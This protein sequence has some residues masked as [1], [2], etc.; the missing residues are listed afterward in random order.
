[1][2]QSEYLPATWFHE[3]LELRPSRIHGKGLFA[4]AP[5]AA[6]ETVMVWRGDLYTEEEL[7]AG[8][9]L[10]SGEWSFSMIDE[11]LY[12]FAPQEGLDYYVNHSCD[13]TVW[14]A[15]EVT[16]V[17]RRDIQPDEEIVGD[18]AVWEADP[19]YIVEP[20]Q[21]WA[22]LCRGRYTG[23]DWQRPDLQA[24]Y[25]AYFLPYLNR[26]IARLQAE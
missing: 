26:R 1:M 22:A 5:I 19:T 18:Y 16:V 15:D 9:S 3:S 8:V 21:C 2:A 14:M 13:P 20:C 25:E 12:L 6:G 10:S 11:G 24:R 17:A 4:T 23:D 7:Q